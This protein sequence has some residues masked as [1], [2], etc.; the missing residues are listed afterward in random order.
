[1]DKWLFTFFLGALLSLFLPIVP[2]IFHI[3]LLLSL[4]FV[5]ILKKA[6]INYTGFLFGCAWILAQDIAYQQDLY[7]LSS[8]TKKNTKQHFFSQAHIVQGKVLSLIDEQNYQ[9]EI[10]ELKLPVNS[11]PK[12][13][14]QHAD[15]RFNLQVTHLNYLPLARPIKIRLRWL[16]P[17]FSIQQGDEVQFS[18]KLKPAY[19]FAN[20]GGFNYQTWLRYKN[21]VATGYI[22]NNTK[23]RSNE[24]K[25]VQT[26]V[27]FRQQQYHKIKTLL[28]DN[29]LS[30]LVLAL[31]L[32]DR[33][34]I[35]KQQWQ[36]LT[37]TGTQHLIAI[38]GL[39]LG[40]IASAIFFIV[41]KTIRYLPLSFLATKI[42]R[43]TITR[44]NHRYIAILISLTFTLFY[45]ALSG[46]ALPTIRALFMLIFYW[47]MRMLAI[48][49]SLT[50]W[51]LL[52][53]FA[54]L[55]TDP[56]SILS[57][58]FWLSF[59]AVI[60]IFLVLWRSFLFYQKSQQ[61][62]LLKVIQSLFIIQ[63]GLSIFLIP[64]TLIIFQQLSTVAFLA[65]I[66]AVPL[67][68][69][70]AIPFSLAGVLILPFSEFLA[71]LFFDWSLIALNFLWQW[72]VFLAEQSWALIPF[73][74]VEVFITSFLII[75]LACFYFCQLNLRYL[76]YA[77]PVFL[78]LV[79]T[80]TLIKPYIW[81]LTVLDVGHGLAV[82]IKQ[83][84]KIVLYDTGAKYPSGFN[85]SEAVILPFLQH[86]N[87]S[88]IDHLIISHNDNDHLGGLAVLQE[89]INIK[90]LIYN[91]QKTNTTGSFCL[92][93]QTFVWQQLTFEQLW[94]NKL[95]YDHNDDSCVIKVSD[96]QSSV[97]LTGDISKRV[98]RQLVASKIDLRADV[99]I[100][101]HHGSKSSSSEQ[102]IKAVNPKVAIFSS[103]YL[104]RWK[105]PTTEVLRRYHKLGIITYTTANNGMIHLLKTDKEMKILT[106]R[107]D[108]FP[109]WFAN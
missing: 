84:K 12:N 76:S 61:H 85:M 78:V 63:L 109:Y 80:N 42:T 22:R 104:N 19:G 88:H 62:W 51:L 56:M 40:L 72:L 99:L 50:R 10:D 34:A 46:F 28:A 27:S 9:D 102:F 77:L 91:D 24:N 18:V 74:S 35:S 36:V 75:V 1:M 108:L 8:I 87:I 68:S 11:S 100:V 103:G 6:V 29:P 86:K 60:V 48:K 94:P 23:K 32:G 93:G 25:L 59:Y 96:K 95:V 53:V 45:A 5:L 97:L 26:D 30:S 106:Y 70:T 20:S 107:Q 105:M 41:V 71:Q 64:I 98:E 4:A 89:H 38:S 2:A 17:E 90:Q 3:V 54:V 21:I 16:E 52:V 82:V 57:A 39:H 31:A 58:S 73:S 14:E 15:L 101:P 55:L 13:N 44:F 47:L 65:N 7:Q 92:Q 79:I 43:S 69:F 49:L 81:Q 83:N 33:S 66:V 37:A 67:M